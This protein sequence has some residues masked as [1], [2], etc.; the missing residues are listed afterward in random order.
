MTQ[1]SLTAIITTH[2]R[3]ELLQ[4][5]L[6]SVQ[7][8]TVP[9]ELIV[10]DDGS[11]PAV[12]ANEV[13]PGTSVVR[14]E[15]AKGAGAAR[16]FGVR[17]AQTEWVAFLDDDDIWLPEKAEAVLEAVGQFPHSNVIF[18]SSS[19]HPSNRSRGTRMLTDPLSRMLHKQ[20]PHISGVAVRKELHLEVPFDETIWATEDLDYLIR[21][22]H[23][24]PWA[25]IRR[26]LTQH[27]DPGLEGSAIDMES[28][29]EG[30]LDLMERHGDLIRNDPTAHSFYYVRLGYQYRRGRHFAEARSCFAKAVRLKPTSGLAWRGLVRVLFS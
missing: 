1:S 19:H 26:D 27:M 15:V 21:L 11:Q 29:I 25:E 5:A 16:N 3:P 24:A 9:V 23:L 10:V 28:R 6:E 4:M 2:N 14:H 20:P 17:E 30:R 8:Q 13:P 12:D 18:H 22:A 7:S